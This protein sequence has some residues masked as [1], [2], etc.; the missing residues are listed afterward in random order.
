MSL[1][2]SERT[3]RNHSVYVCIYYIYRYK[4]TCLRFRLSFPL[5]F[6]V[7]SAR[8]CPFREFQIFHY[9]LRSEVNIKM[10]SV[11]SYMFYLS[12]H[13]SEKNLDITP[14]DR[15]RIKVTAQ[16]WTV[17]RPLLSQTVPEILPRK[18]TKYVNI[19]RARTWN[20]SRIIKVVK[21]YYISDW[22]YQSLLLRERSRLNHLNISVS[23]KL[24]ASKIQPCFLRVSQ[25]TK[26][27]FTVAGISRNGGRERCSDYGDLLRFRR[28]P[29]QRQSGLRAVQQSSWTQDGSNA[30]QQ[31]GQ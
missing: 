3:C 7:C 12:A 25:L 8:V 1:S 29:A 2:F 23:T 6:A 15:F 11:P 4:F 10:L 18:T 16:T 5:N 19:L 24:D 22:I 17:V 20:Y 30:L 31:R 13:K 27:S 26:S 9:D 14:R 21:A 28:G